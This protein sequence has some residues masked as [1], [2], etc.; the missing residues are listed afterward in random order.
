M[1][2]K[3]K[4]FNIIKSNLGLFLFSLFFVILYREFLHTYNSIRTNYS[5]FFISTTNRILFNWK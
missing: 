2:T 1:N 3:N 4:I 5:I